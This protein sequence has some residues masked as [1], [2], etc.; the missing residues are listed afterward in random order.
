MYQAHP[1][2]ITVYGLKDNIVTFDVLKLPDIV[3][4]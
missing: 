1:L 3:S 4:R 2:L